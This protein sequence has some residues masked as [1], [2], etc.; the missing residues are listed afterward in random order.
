MRGVGGVAARRWFPWPCLPRQTGG[1]A[2]THA[3]REAERQR[4][5]E[6]ERERELP[7]VM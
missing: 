2:G 1:R 4:E 3:R 7:A 5:R 6:R